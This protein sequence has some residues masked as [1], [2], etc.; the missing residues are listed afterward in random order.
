MHNDKA[1]A[2]Y[3]SQHE[4]CTMIKYHIGHVDFHYYGETNTDIVMQYS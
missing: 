1:Q 4:H 2:S 3:K